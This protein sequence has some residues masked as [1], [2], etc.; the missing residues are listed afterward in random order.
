MNKLNWNKKL[1]K[2][3]WSKV[4]LP[5]DLINECW[6]WTAGTKQDGYGIFYL[7][8]YVNDNKVRAHRLSYEY[9]HGSINPPDLFVCHKCDNPIC[10]NPNHLFLGTNQENQYDRFNK[11]RQ[12]I[13]T[14]NGRSKLTELDVIDIRDLFKNGMT[15]QELANLYNMGWTTIS[16]IIKRNNWKNI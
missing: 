9:Y 16:N 1:E 13:G 8:G 5:K 2:R 10:V 4:Q 15:I 12:A 3:F 11:D 6:I 14:K 7:K